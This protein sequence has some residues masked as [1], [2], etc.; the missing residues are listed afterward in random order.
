MLFKILLKRLNK[1]ESDGRDM[2]HAWNMRNACQVWQAKLMG[3]SEG[4]RLRAKGSIMKYD[5]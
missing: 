2:T 5:F 1:T 3:L 4:P